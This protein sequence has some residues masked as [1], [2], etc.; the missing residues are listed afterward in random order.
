MK[1]AI[2]ARYSTDQ[3][4]RTSIDGQYRNAETF[5]AEQ[6]FKVTARFKDEAHQRDQRSPGWIPSDARSS[7]APRVRRPL[8]DETSRLSRNPWELPRLLEELQFRS[9]FVLA[10]GFDSRQESSHLLA[11]LYGGMDRLE[12]PEDQGADSPRPARAPPRAAFRRAARRS[13]MEAPQPILPIPRHDGTRL[14]SRRRE[15][16]RFDLRTVRRRHGGEGYCV[17]TQSPRRPLPRRYLEPSRSAY[18]RQM[19][20]QRNSRCGC[21]LQRHPAQ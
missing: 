15:V 18:G 1:V 2:Y 20:A 8:S 4:D 13:A 19:A 11:G 14:R 9:Q 6:G 16:G 17:G 10:R 21:S 3:Q 12:L 5:A 7:R